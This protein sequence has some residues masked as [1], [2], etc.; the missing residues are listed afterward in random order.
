MTLAK[1]QP[2]SLGSKGGRNGWWVREEK[3]KNKKDNFE[4]S[5]DPGTILAQNMQSTQ[6]A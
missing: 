1:C 5:L 2:V 4:K 6:S 3:K